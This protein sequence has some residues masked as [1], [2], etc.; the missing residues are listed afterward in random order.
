[1]VGALF[2][3]INIG[4]KGVPGNAGGG[5]DRE[6]VFGGETPCFSHP[7]AHGGLSESHQTRHRGLRADSF[8]CRDECLFGCAGFH[9]SQQ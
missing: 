7:P 1:M 8:D 3:R 2:E 5:F 6:D 4:A 9:E